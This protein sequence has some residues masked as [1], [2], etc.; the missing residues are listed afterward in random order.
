MLGRKRG[1]LLGHPKLLGAEGYPFLYSDFLIQ[2]TPARQVDCAF[3]RPK[4]C[5]FPTS[6]PDDTPGGLQNDVRR[7][8]PDGGARL[9][10][11]RMPPGKGNCDAPLTLGAGARRKRSHRHQCAPGAV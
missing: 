5:G 3:K 2:R 6:G 1:R 10:P 8:R 11:H 9:A 7:Q 4:G